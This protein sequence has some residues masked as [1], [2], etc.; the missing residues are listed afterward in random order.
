MLMICSTGCL[1]N[2]CSTAAWSLS[3][4]ERCRGRYVS[5]CTSFRALCESSCSC[6]LNCYLSLDLHLINPSEKLFFPFS[7][8]FYINFC[9]SHLFEKHLFFFLHSL[10][11]KLQSWNLFCFHNVLSKST[12]QCLLDDNILIPFFLE[13]CLFLRHLLCFLLHLDYFIL[14][15]LYFFEVL[16]DR[17]NNLIPG[18]LDVPP[19]HVHVIHRLRLLILIRCVNSLYEFAVLVVISQ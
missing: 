2:C 5:S 1:C 19:L 18:T 3:D 17:G 16:A 7:H 14:D 4:R 10:D 11:I 9:L 6:L 13:L 15:N 8:G 12:F